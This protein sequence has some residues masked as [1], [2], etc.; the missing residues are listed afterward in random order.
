[1]FGVTGVAVKAN[2]FALGLGTGERTKQHAIDQAEDAR[3][4]A[5]PEGQDANRGERKAGVFPQQPHAVTKVLP[6]GPHGSL[7]RLRVFGSSFQRR[8]KPSLSK[9]S[10]SLTFAFYSL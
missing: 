6:Q 9:L 8:L 4:H 5:N 10:P 7:I 2:Q 1:M 3:V